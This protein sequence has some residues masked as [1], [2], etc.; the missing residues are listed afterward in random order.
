MPSPQAPR[1][2]A[3][4]R[5]G[6]CRIC[7]LHSDEVGELSYRGKCEACALARQS[8]SWRSLVAHE[9]EPFQEWRKGMARSVG[10]KLPPPE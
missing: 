9:G 4:P 8:H 10:A 7:G 6:F 2:G 1:K 5:V 3:Q